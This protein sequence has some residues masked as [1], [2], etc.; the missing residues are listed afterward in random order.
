M[1]LQKVKPSQNLIIHN[2]LN[3]QRMVW[4]STAL[5]LIGHAKESCLHIGTSLVKHEAH[6]FTIDKI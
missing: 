1:H 6:I 4:Q 5:S 3:R 2:L